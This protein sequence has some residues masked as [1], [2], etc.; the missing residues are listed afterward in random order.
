MA[1]T[2]SAAAL[3]PGAMQGERDASD[4]DVMSVDTNMNESV[5]KIGLSRMEIDQQEVERYSITSTTLATYPHFFLP[6]LAS[7][8][9]NTEAWNEGD[10]EQQTEPQDHAL[11]PWTRHWLSELPEWKKLPHQKKKPPSICCH[12]NHQRQSHPGYTT[13]ATHLQPPK[14]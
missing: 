7:M 5:G 12:Q 8:L 4:N 2:S 11:V 6:V 1:S 10:Q 13:D 14:R 3:L 9:S